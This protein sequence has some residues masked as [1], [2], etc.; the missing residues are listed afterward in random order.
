MN[1]LIV[2][3]HPNP[4]S[5]NHAILDSVVTGLK[6]ADHTPKIKDLYTL[7]LKI[8][9]DAEDLEQIVNGKTP[10]D[11]LK[12][13]QDILWAEGLIFIYPIWWYDRPAILKGWID[14]V[15]LQGFA[16]DTDADGIKGLLIHK[17]AIIF[18]TTGGTE[19]MFTHIGTDKDVFRHTMMEGTLQF[20]GI[21]NIIYKPFYGVPHISQADREQMLSETYELGKNF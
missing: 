19:A 20:C 13:Q 8:T 16:F 21:Q 2:Y 10:D 3:A 6:E 14:R 5:F 12:E 15:F 9:L 18:Q 7:S 4:N 17:K 11:I 1:V